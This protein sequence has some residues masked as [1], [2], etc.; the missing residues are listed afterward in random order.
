MECRLD[1]GKKLTLRI[2]LIY[3]IATLRP[4]I[5]DVVMIKSKPDVEG[6]VE[7]GETAKFLA[8]QGSSCG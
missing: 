6:E 3:S 1:F 4:A 5:D 8:L 7:R 2:V